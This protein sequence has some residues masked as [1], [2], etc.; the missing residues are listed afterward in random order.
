MGDQGRHNENLE[1]RASEILV[2]GTWKHQRAVLVMPAGKSIPYRVAAA[3]RGIITPPNQAFAMLGAEGMEVGD[4]YSR[5]VEQIL[6]DP[7]LSTWEY[8]LF[9]EHDNLP[10][11]DGYL[12]LIKAME[13]HPEYAAIGGLYWTK[14][15]GGV[16]QIW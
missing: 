1:A 13:A 6:A 3:M 11:P 14:G 8:L 5:L 15:E 9:M 12:K 4:A 10:P 7:N 2:G 16:P